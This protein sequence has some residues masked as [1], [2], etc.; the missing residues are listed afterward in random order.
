MQ[1]VLATCKG[2]RLR[3]AQVLGIGRT[4]LYRDLKEDGY[5]QT[6]IARSKAA[7]Q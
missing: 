4:S 2:N 6:L 1:R 3:A 7:G 5:D